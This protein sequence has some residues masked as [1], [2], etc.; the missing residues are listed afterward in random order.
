VKNSREWITEKQHIQRLLGGINQTVERPIAL[1]AR[2]FG[3]RTRDITLLP[4]GG[5]SR[6]ERMPN[7]PKQELLV[8]M[9]GPAVNVVLA[10]LLLLLTCISHRVSSRGA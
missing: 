3:I 5:V 4:I 8:A 2:R 1:T 7:G 6:L 10:A 9:A